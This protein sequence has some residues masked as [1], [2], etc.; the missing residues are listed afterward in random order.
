MGRIKK[1]RGRRDERQGPLQWTP[2]QQSCECVIEWGWD[3][4]HTPP[5]AFIEW[6]LAM[7]D[8]PCVWHG[9]DTGLD[10]PLDQETVSLTVP[11]GR[12]RARRAKGDRCELGVELTRQA[13]DMREK[14]RLDDVAGLLMD[15]PAKYQ[16]I[17]KSRGFDPVQTWVE[18]RLAD[19][20]L[21]LGRATLTDEMLERLPENLPEPGAPW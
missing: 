21:N 15:I 4:Q 7:I 9:A 6:C 16:R 13:T 20:F 8:A 14:T 19:I 12:L 3:P 1:N 17:M 5:Q 11:Q 10:I 18:M 2:V